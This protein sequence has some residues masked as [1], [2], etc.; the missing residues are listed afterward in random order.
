MLDLDD[1][2]D[3]YRLIDGNEEEVVEMILDDYVGRK[4]FPSAIDLTPDV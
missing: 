3:L 1:P 2:E 4:T